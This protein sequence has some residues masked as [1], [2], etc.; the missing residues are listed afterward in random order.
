MWLIVYF[1][2]YFPNGNA[3]N[4]LFAIKMLVVFNI[5]MV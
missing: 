3:T 4:Y 2:L 1:K 5:L